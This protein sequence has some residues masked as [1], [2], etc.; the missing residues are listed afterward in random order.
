MDAKHRAWG[1][2]LFISSLGTYRPFLPATV[3]DMLDLDYPT[4]G[5]IAYIT[6]KSINPPNPDYLIASLHRGPT[7]VPEPCGY[8]VLLLITESNMMVRRIFETT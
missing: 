1:N 6:N 2:K 8:A 4:P 3:P 7:I 5:F